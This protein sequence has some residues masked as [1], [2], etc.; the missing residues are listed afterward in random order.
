M[1]KQQIKANAPEG[2]THVDHGGIYW[3]LVSSYE[4]YFTVDGI[5]WIRF[6]LPIDIAINNGL[7]KPL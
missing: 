5:N 1:T 2:S 7:I 6:D 4:S 3:K